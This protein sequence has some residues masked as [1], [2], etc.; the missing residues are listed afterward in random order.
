MPAPTPRRRRER[1][2]R[3]PPRRS[4]TPARRAF[5]RL[6]PQLDD[7]KSIRGGSPPPHAWAPKRYVDPTPRAPV[8]APYAPGR[9][10][11]HRKVNT[12][13]APLPRRHAWG[14]PGHAG[15]ADILEARR[16]RQPEV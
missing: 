10:G 7:V 8:P 14:P 11:P 2:V 5:S 12:Q 15:A 3:P 6:P 13:L 1:V 9:S 4:N 16:K